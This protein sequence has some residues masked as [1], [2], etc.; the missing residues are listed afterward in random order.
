MGILVFFGGM[1]FGYFGKLILRGQISIILVFGIGK[2][3]LG[4]KD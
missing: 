1:N 2:Y 3:L 4:Y